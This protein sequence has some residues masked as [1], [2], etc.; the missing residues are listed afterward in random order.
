MS[1]RPKARARLLTAGAALA[2]AAALVA[3]SPAPA[4]V[5]AAPAPSA[6]AHGYTP[7]S[8]DDAQNAMLQSR[9]DAA[10][11]KQATGKASALAVTTVYYDA[12]RAPS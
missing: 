10:L 4:G 6:P 11:A 12:S 1:L 8:R 3:T 9:L 2:A 7:G 5:T